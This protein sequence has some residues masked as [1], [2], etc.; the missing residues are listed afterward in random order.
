MCGLEFEG[1]ECH[2][3]CPFALGCN[4]IRCPRCDYE[5]VETGLLVSLLRRFM[6]DRKG[7]SNPDATKGITR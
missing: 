7:S 3:S 5:F 4:M 6:P 1:A 2:S